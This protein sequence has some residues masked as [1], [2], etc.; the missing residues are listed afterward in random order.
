MNFDP[1]HVHHQI[2][3]VHRHA[4]LL[5]FIILQSYKHRFFMFSFSVSHNNMHTAK[6][7]WATDWHKAW[8]K[9]MTVFKNAWP[10]VK[11]H[12]IGGVGRGAL[13]SSCAKALGLERSTELYNNN[14]KWFSTLF[15]FSKMR[16]L[17]SP[18][19]CKDKPK[20]SWYI[21]AGI[22]TKPFVFIPCA[23]TH[24]ANCLSDNTWQLVECSPSL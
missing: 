6:R 5:N 17:Q 22:T 13:C 21:F 3:Y 19:G 23:W 24:E 11:T 7:P 16:R 2:Q 14:S 4:L 12:T 8:W 20:G 10:N 18:E 9:Q 15:S 1:P